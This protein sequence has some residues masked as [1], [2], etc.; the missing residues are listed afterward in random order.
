MLLIGNGESRSG[1]DIDNINMHKVGC[2][3]VYRD[4]HVDELV[5]VDR[6]MVIEACQAEFKGNIYTRDNWVKYFAVKY[7]NVKSVPKLPYEGDKRHDDP[8]HWGSGN[9][10]QLVACQTHHKKIYVLGFDLWGSGEGQ[11]K[12]NNVYKGTENYNKVDHRAVDPR[13][14]IIH[15]AKLAEVY[16]YKKFIILANQ[17]WKRPKEW[18]LSNIERL[19]I[20]K[21][22]DIC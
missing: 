5:C 15:F 18:S 12:H 1:I 3:A 10:A 8:F 16:K 6:R 4:F 20:D 13:Y 17:D 11:Y 19:D 9:F 2:N 14:W 7:P 22:Y 21:V